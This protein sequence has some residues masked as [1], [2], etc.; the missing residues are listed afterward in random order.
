MDGEGVLI[1]VG[2][3]CSIKK[4]LTKQFYKP[5][6]YPQHKIPSRTKWYPWTLLRPEGAEIKKTT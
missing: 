4:I 5:M 2:P 3:P 6:W 1:Y